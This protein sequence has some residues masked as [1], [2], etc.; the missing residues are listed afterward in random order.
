MSI[1]RQMN[2]ECL[3]NVDSVR[4]DLSLRDRMR[5]NGSRR[6]FGGDTPR[7]SPIKLNTGPPNTSQYT[8]NFSGREDT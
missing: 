1:Y 2:V 7:A 5:G 6:C 4:L 3:E 8:R